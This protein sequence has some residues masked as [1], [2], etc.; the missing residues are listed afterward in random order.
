MGDTLERL[1]DLGIYL[2]LWGISDRLERLREEQW[3]LGTSILEGIES[4][5]EAIER[6]RLAQEQQTRVLQTGLARIDARLDFQTYLLRGILDTLYRPTDVE[7]QEL[8]ARGERELLRAHYDEALNEFSKAIEKNPYDF[9]CH[10][11]IAAICLEHFQDHENAWESCELALRYT[12][13]HP[14]PDHSQAF[15]ASR[16]L[17]LM[18]RMLE[19]GGLLDA[20]LS[21][22]AAG[23][24]MSPDYGECFRLFGR[25]AALLGEPDLALESLRIAILID[26]DE[27]EKIQ[28]DEA[29][30]AI[31]PQ[32]HSL[33]EHQE[34]KESERAAA[35]AKLAEEELA[36]A[37]EWD[38]IL[39]QA[40]HD[41]AAAKEINDLDNSRRRLE[42]TLQTARTLAAS[43]DSLGHAWAL[44]TLREIL[45]EISGGRF[46]EF[47]GLR[48]RIQALGRWAVDSWRGSVDSEHGAHVDRVRSR[49]AGDLGKAE[50][51]G[52]GCL[53]QLLL[54]FLALAGITMGSLLVIGGVVY[55]DA[56]R[57]LGGIVL[58]VAPFAFFVLL[59]TVGGRFA[60]TRVERKAGSE[61][62]NLEEHWSNKRQ[63]L[64]ETERR[65]K[66]AQQ[67]ASEAYSRARDL[68]TQNDLRCSLVLVDPR[69]MQDHY[70][71]TGLS[72]ALRHLVR[73]YSER[74]AFSIEEAKSAI[75]GAP[76]ILLDNLSVPDAEGIAWYLRSEFGVSVGL[77]RRYVG[78]FPR[79]TSDALA[80]GP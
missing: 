37:Y 42:R 43:G 8:R 7:A 64:E 74:Q 56:A 10:Y 14:S 19:E 16:A 79:S 80:S 11:N 9:S 2:E 67:R 32:I 55:G 15:F 30:A 59:S 53:M 72:K 22:Y 5:A 76:T 1:S 35:V 69:E 63:A 27:K 39:A 29:L 75:R 47:R 73:S 33:I 52:K 24:E 77:K 57:I 34:R 78:P 17:L 6:L 51:T 48:G 26:G 58:I 68:L 21:Y 61:L 18:G 71:E 3:L 49:E 4:V 50:N 45:C 12:E 41:D 25:A 65:W 36:A 28:K 20:A 44:G 13:P 46:F 31:G 54:F 23:C 40:P 60:K 66:A 62:R 38:E 70:D